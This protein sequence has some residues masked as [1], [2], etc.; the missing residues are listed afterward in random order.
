VP[1]L[2]D[3]SGRRKEG[4]GARLPEFLLAAGKKENQNREEERSGESIFS[5][6]SPGASFSFSRTGGGKN[7][8]GGNCQGGE[9][10]SSGR[11]EKGGVR[12]GK[13]EITGCGDY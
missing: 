9:G 8:W 1:P 3:L 4:G 7:S 11:M 13:E 12:G 10:P 6:G 5:R 2:L